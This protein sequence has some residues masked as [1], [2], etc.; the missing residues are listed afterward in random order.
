MSGFTHLFSPQNLALLSDWLDEM[1]ELYVDLYYPHSAG[2]S[3]AYIVR[4]MDELKSL[5]AKDNFPE[6]E[7]TI[8]R[9]RQ[10]PLRGLADAALL[11]KALKLIPDGELYSIVSFNLDEHPCR[12]Y[13][14][15]DGRS[16]EQF[17]R[18]FT[19]VLGET[20]GIGQEPILVYNGEW[21]RSHPSEVFVLSVH[22]NQS[23]YEPFHK[24][25]EKYNRIINSWRE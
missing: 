22:R 20:V 11:E 4:S 6:I 21:I 24:N 17:R 7:V 14:K 12:F 13:F 5:I 1:G 18:E 19:D 15:G 3:I 8:F 9:S 23:Y 2:S 25:P 16:H 10:F